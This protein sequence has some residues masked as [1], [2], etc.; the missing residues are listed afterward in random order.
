M[1]TNL[2]A[3]TVNQSRRQ[4]KGLV[5]G[6]ILIIIGLATLLGQFGFVQFGEYVTGLV[7]AIFILAAFLRRKNGMLVPG[8]IL[9]GINAGAL[10]QGF[11]P[12]TPAGSGAFL[13]AFAGG[14][15][16]ISLLSGVL[17]RIDASSKVMLWPLIPG[18]IIGAVGGLLLMGPNGIYLLSQLSLVWPVVLI[19]LG[20]WIIL[21]RR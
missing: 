11:H 17:N 18:G 20:L 19:L 4:H 15:L 10:L 3:N 8:G 12:T 7:G 5:G 2:D 21:R 1:V 6:A 16:L 13:L 9:L 14:W